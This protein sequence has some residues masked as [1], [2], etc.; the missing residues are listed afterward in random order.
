MR[1]VSTTYEEAMYAPSYRMYV[2]ATFDP[3]RTYFSTLTDNYAFDTSDYSTTTNTP[4]GQCMVWDANSGKTKTFVVD[5]SA[6]K[7]MTQGS[8]A[9]TTVSGATID[10]HVKPAAWYSDTGVATLRWWNGS[11][12]ASANCTLSNFSLSSIS[13][14]AVECD[15]SWTTGD[16]SLVAVSATQV[17]ALYQ[18]SKGGIGVSYYDGSGWYKWEHRFMSPKSITTDYWPIYSAAAILGNYLFVYITDMDTGEVQGLRYDIANNLWGDT[19]IALPADLTRYNVTNA[20]VANSYIHLA[21]QF[22]R[23]GD[24]AGAQKYSQVLRSSDGYNFSW[25]RYTLLSRLGYTFSIALDTVNK[26]LYA[27][28]RN[29]V[30]GSAASIFFVAAPTNRLTLSPPGTIISFALRGN[31]S[32]SMRIKA[33][34]ETY[35]THAAVQKGCRVIVELGFHTSLGEEWC[36][37]GR[38]II[39]TKAILYQDGKRNVEL[40]LIAEGVWKTSQIAFPYYAEINGKPSVFDDCDEKDTL[41]PAEGSAKTTDK[42]VI[43]FW[44]SEGWAKGTECTEYSWKTATGAGCEHKVITGAFAY[45][46]QTAELTTGQG[47]SSLPELIST[48]STV[49]VYGWERSSISARTNSTVT[50]YLITQDTASVESIVAGTKISTYDIFPQEY[51]DNHSGSYPIAYNFTGLTAGNK[52]KRIAL[53]IVNTNTENDSDIAFER[54]SLEGTSHSFSALT[55]EAAKG[56]TQSKPTTGYYSTV[57]DTILELETVGIASVHFATKPYSAFKFSAY[58]EFVYEAGSET[59]AQGTIA[60]G[61]V[62]IAE[63]GSNLIIGRYSL[64]ATRLEIV[65]LRDGEETLLAYHDVAAATPTKIMMEHRDGQLYLRRYDDS[66][67]EWLEPECTYQWDE[68]TH[69]AM[70]TSS[71]AIMHVG[72][73]MAKVPPGF[74]IPSF[75][76]QDGT[77]GIATIAGEDHT[78]FDALPE[79]GKVQINNS[80]YQYT[81]VYSSTVEYGPV[82]ARNTGNYGEY[83]GEDGTGFSGTGVEIGLYHPD[84]SATLLT[85]LLVASDNGHTWKITQT[86]WNVIHSN[87]GVPNPLRNRSRQYGA[88][89]KGNYVGTNSRMYISPGLLAVENPSGEQGSYHPRGEF[90]FLYGTDRIWLANFSATV[91]DKDTTIKDM[92]KTLCKVAS[93]E[94]SFP[95]DYSETASVTSSGTQIATTKELFP[96]GYEL[97]VEANPSANDGILAYATN[98]TFSGSARRFGVK[99]VS[100]KVVAISEKTDGTDSQLFSSTIPWTTTATIR[101]L[102]HSNFISIYFNDI[103]VTTWGF[104]EDDV[105][106]PTD[107]LTMYLKSITSPYSIPVTVTELF[108]WR[109]SIFVES[110]MNASG[111]ISSVI[112]ERPVEIYPTA[113]GGLS[114]SYEMVRETKELTSAQCKNVLRKHT[115]IDSTGQD[116]GSDAIIYYKDIA[117]S[118][119]DNFA[120]DEGF[121]T[122]VLKLSNLDYGA[123][124]A[125]RMILRKANQKQH[126][127]KLDMR[128][129]PQLE[130]GDIIVVNYTTTGTGTVIEKAIIIEDITIDIGEVSQI[131]SI[132]GR[133]TD[134]PA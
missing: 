54:V 28:D 97:T 124:V 35:Y 17:V 20:I 115:S 73:Y 44:N 95:G 90:C 108:D 78:A 42:L 37:I 129:N 22:C 105:V 12:M 49:S 123:D 68:V 24:V 16:V 27:S 31:D 26:V 30:S 100:N 45:G 114:F 5:G 112:Q 34:N 57:E 110:E 107:E 86:E 133:E 82:C 92:I 84:S 39:D 60:W 23:T 98:L 94:A 61:V 50:A 21:G 66:T 6:L 59:I 81:T 109:E 47:L 77:D 51:P 122:R 132:S 121:V 74:R 3:C 38:F 63:D 58:G 96:G 126:Q 134:V 128:P 48:V 79:P 4:I 117:F 46:L 55:L 32:A 89:V 80:I 53:K 127:E 99:K 19:F 83:T 131:M 52:V 40:G 43:D 9:Q 104:D 113:T 33:A 62:G 65:K 119:D 10:G 91:I 15:A 88:N 118:T 29:C 93:I 67:G 125:G 64:K 101:I 41:Y 2:R 7:G 70:S 120:D 72:A 116:A 87:A 13:T 111:A 11:A 102:M 71:T 1:T 130:P 25:D 14:T 18:T 69:G 36:E 8:T 85:N 56:L 75:N 76:I 106:W 103:W